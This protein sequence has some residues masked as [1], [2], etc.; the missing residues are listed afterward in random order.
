MAD[1]DGPAQILLLLLTDGAII[2]H[3]CRANGVCYSHATLA[4]ELG[5]IGKVKD[6]GFEYPNGT[7][8]F[9]ST[10]IEAAHKE[11]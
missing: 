10:G 5:V 2:S 1:E 3:P 8:W 9:R 4:D 7:R 11:S 6:R